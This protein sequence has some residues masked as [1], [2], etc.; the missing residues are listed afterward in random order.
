MG[1]DPRTLRSQPEL[2]SRVGCLTNCVPCPKCPCPVKLMSV[3]ISSECHHSVTLGGTWPLLFTVL[4]QHMLK[5]IPSGRSAIL[6]PAFAEQ[7][8]I[9]PKF[10]ILRKASQKQVSLFQ[11][12]AAFM[13]LTYYSNSLISSQTFLLSVM[14]DKCHRKVHNK[15][16]SG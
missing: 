10:V 15:K 12:L 2:K 7:Q 13:M 9:V 8:R 4:S 16:I 3:L 6:L 5:R 1:L 11:E 14:G